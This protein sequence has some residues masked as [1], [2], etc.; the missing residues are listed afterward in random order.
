ML[1]YNNL[2][3]GT[4]QSHA[5]MTYAT[6]TATNITPLS[7][8]DSSP[9]AFMNN[10][11]KTPH[12]IPRATF[13]NNNLINS[14]GHNSTTLRTSFFHQG[15]P[16]VTGLVNNQDF[17]NSQIFRGG[18]FHPNFQVPANLGSSSIG[19]GSVHQTQI[20]IPNA[21]FFGKY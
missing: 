11:S 17:D 15:D 19:P 20:N 6:P 2:L 14:A 9:E 7:Q 10:R 18:S 16:Q 1:S 3:F 12:Y 21:C 5:R 4:S 8:R 13:G